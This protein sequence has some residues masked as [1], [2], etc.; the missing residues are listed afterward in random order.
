MSIVCKICMSYS[1]AVSHV[2]DISHRS[3]F[4]GQNII[5]WL[6]TQLLTSTTNHHPV[7]YPALYNM[8]INIIAFYL[9]LPFFNDTVMILTHWENVYSLRKIRESKVHKPQSLNK[10][11][12]WLNN[13]SDQVWT[14]Q[15]AA[16]YGNL[17]VFLLLWISGE[18]FLFQFHS[19]LLPARE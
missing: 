6:D 10:N 16:V 5:I 11:L 13:L 3:F 2:L 9:E 17:T 4:F 18:M 15:H 8:D 19:V 14:L 7:Q 1:W 12:S